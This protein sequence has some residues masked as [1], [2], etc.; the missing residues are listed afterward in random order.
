MEMMLHSTSG[1]VGRVS[2]ESESKAFMFAQRM[3]AH[4]VWYG[5]ILRIT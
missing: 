3:F 2:F 1:N 5:V 4:I